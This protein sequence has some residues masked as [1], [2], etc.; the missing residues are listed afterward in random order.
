MTSYVMEAR[1]SYTPDIIA[2][3]GTAYATQTNQMYAGISYD[4]VRG[5]I[6]YCLNYAD[7]A[8]DT[9]LTGFALWTGQT[10]IGKGATYDATIYKN[11]SIMEKD[12][13]TDAVVRYDAWSSSKIIPAGKGGGNPLTGT[14][15]NPGS[16]YNNGTAFNVAVISNSGVNPGLTGGIDALMNLTFS[17]GQL[18]SFTFLQTGH[19]YSGT[20]V[21]TFDNTYTGYFGSGASVTVNTVSPSSDGTWRRAVEANAVF[22][23]GSVQSITF[24]VPRLV[25]PVTG[26][27]WAHHLA[28][29]GNSCQIYLLKRSSGFVQEISPMGPVPAITPNTN[30]GLHMQPMGISANWFYC[31]NQQ[32][33]ANPSFLV[34]RPLDIT[35]S[36]ITADYLLPYAWYKWP[37]PDWLADQQQADITG[38]SKA[39]PCVITYNN[40]FRAPN[41]GDYILINSVSGMTQLNGTTCIMQNLNTGAGTFE[42]HNLDGTPL[43]STGFSTYTHG[44]S[45]VQLV[46]A[47]RTCFDLSNNFY[48]ISYQW[49]NQGKGC[50]RQY[51]LQ[52]FTEPSSAAAYQ[53]ATVGGG[54][55]DITPWG[56]SNG[57]NTSLGSNTWNSYVG[58]IN[59]SM[60][61]Y[62]PSSNNLWIVTKVW[63]SD[64]NDGLRN[65]TTWGQTRI[66]ATYVNLTGNTFD[67]HTS[68]LTGY[69]LIDN[70][71][72]AITNS[73]LA[74]GNYAL[75]QIIELDTDIGYHSYDFSQSP[76]NFDY[77]KRWFFLALYPISGGV[78]TPPGTPDNPANRTLL[79]QVQFVPGSAPTILQTIWDTGWNSAYTSYATAI[80]N[81]NVVTASANN[82]E[83]GIQFFT[84]DSGVTESTNTAWWWGGQTNTGAMYNLNPAWA[85]RAGIA[86]G[87]GIGIAQPFLRMSLGAPPPPPP[88]TFLLTQ[89]H[90]Y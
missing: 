42:L 24:N 13:N 41:N 39:S 67:Y 69:L 72:G 84:I 88:P 35:A 23:R 8:T 19:N 82:T 80:G 75:Q 45:A 77:T 58:Y 60:I 11:H 57:P 3:F 71:T 5:K 90:I 81:P 73:N 21:F 76:V 63:G 89:G 53:S 17:G 50:A 78:Y 40:A 6:M 44:G 87:S 31:L 59:N 26:H 49:D 74:N 85:S 79:I 86:T 29:A 10:L 64:L 12:I 37:Y 15:T 54:F 62:L 14:I 55:T 61:G 2:L 68:W 36:D 70:T 32:N 16:G 48:A 28:G 66:D 27:V 46:W 33:R 56:V 7:A 47:S 34:L 65:S 30:G 22:V 9:N 51:R 18:V 43:D 25:D 20:E 38:A 4:R 52:K 83:Q 1:E